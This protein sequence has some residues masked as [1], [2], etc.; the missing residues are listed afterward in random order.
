MTGRPRIYRR[1][2]ELVLAVLEFLDQAID[3]VPWT[4]LVDRFSSPERPWKAVE[5]VLYD[6]AHFGAVHRVGKAAYGRRKD[7]R[8]VRLTELGSAWLHGMTSLPLVGG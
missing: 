1:E 4:E 6:L 3:A 8:A 2:P 7:E 5:N